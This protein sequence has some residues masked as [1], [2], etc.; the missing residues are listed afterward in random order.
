MDGLD[1]YTV[2]KQN[3]LIV[4]VFGNKIANGKVAANA[5]Q[6]L[7][8]IKLTFLVL[9]VVFEVEESLFELARDGQNLT[10]TVGIHPIDNLLKPFVSFPNEILLRKI[11]DINLGLCCDTSPVTD[12][13]Y[14]GIFEF[15]S[16]DWSV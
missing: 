3:A 2:K 15:S 14:F 4:L 6:S 11:H 9:W 8:N 13:I 5:R 1:G 16:L 12:D 7:C 10:P